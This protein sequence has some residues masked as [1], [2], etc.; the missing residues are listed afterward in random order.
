[1]DGLLSQSPQGLDL[2]IEEDATNLSA[3][4]KQSIAI[5][6]A[7]LRKPDVYIFDEATCNMD[8]KRGEAVIAYLMSMSE[9]CIFV[10]HDKAIVEKADSIIWLGENGNE[11]IN[12]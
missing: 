12:W 3:G 4:Q 1:M 6:R 10:T 2:Y 9:P 5:A 8:P 11:E 7:L